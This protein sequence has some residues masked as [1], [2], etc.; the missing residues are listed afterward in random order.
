YPPGTVFEFWVT[1]G[2][3]DPIQDVPTSGN[4]LGNFTYQFTSIGDYRVQLIAIEPTNNCPYI[5]EELITV[6][7][8]AEARFFT[9]TSG[10]CAPWDA[11]F[12]DDSNDTTIV[13]RIWNVIGPGVNFTQ[14]F[15]S[16]TNFTYTF[17]NNTVNPID[18]DV[19]YTVENIYGCRNAKV[20]TVT[21]FPQLQPSFTV[22]P[23]TQTL[24]SSTVTIVDTT[25]A[26]PWD[27]RWDFG[28]GTFSTDPNTSTHTYGTFGVFPITLEVTDPTT[29]CIGIAY[30][31]VEVIAIPP[32]V[33]FDYDTPNGCAPVTVNFTN[34]SQYASPGTFQWDFGDGIGTSRQQ[35]PTY[36]YYDPGTYT[37]TLSASNELDS[38]VTERKEFIIEV[39]A[40]AVANFSVRPEEVF[41]PD[42][43]IR[44]VNRSEGA[45]SY[46]WDFGDGNGSTEF[47]P[48]HKYEK[49]GNYDVTLIVTSVNGCSDSLTIEKA[50][51]A[52]DGGKFLIPNTFTPNGDGQNDTFKPEIVG[53]V[54]FYM[55]IYDRWGELLY[56]TDQVSDPGW[57]GNFNGKPVTQDVYVYKVKMKFISGKNTVKTGDVTLLR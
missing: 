52:N 34:L 3:N 2:A 44:L 32:V 42:E 25:P 46:L 36:T 13:R 43:S 11:I 51:F 22:T 24:P 9:P 54:D 8:E 1:Y 29:G 21:A 56:V 20:E 55:E 53:V 33:D 26:N 35:N 40:E 16:K 10:D 15:A 49:A 4:L 38:V 18:Y 30:D 37:V 17:L 28:D 14:E 57:D 39:Y 48:I 31:T 23:K 12:F 6:Y 27:Y 41:L 50:V 5:D 19:T 7:P 45:D 47:E